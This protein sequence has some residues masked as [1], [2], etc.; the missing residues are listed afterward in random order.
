MYKKFSFV[1]ELL[2]GLWGKTSPKSEGVIGQ[3]RHGD[4][5]RGCECGHFE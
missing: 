4:D 1:P 5:Y 2:N 3:L